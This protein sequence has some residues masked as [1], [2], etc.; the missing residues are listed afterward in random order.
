MS[1]ATMAERAAHASERAREMMDDNPNS[2]VSKARSLVSGDA[3][4]FTNT[5]K[6]DQIRKQLDSDSVSDKKD[7]MK[8]VIAQICKGANMAMLF[9]D[10]VKNIHVSSIELRKLVYYFIV[11]YAEERPNESLLS[12]SAFQKDLLDHS[13]HVRSLALRILSS[14][15]IP[16]IN[17]VVM[18]AIKKA[19][20]DMSSVVRK[21]AAISL[22]QAHSISGTDNDMELITGLLHQF[23]GDRS[24]EVVGA[25]ALSFMEICPSR[26]DLVHKHFRK[27]CRSLVDSDEWGQVVLLHMLLRYARTQFKNPDAAKPT[28]EEKDKAKDEKKAKKAAAKDSDDSDDSSSSDSDDEIANLGDSI[29]MDSDHRLLLNSVRPLFMSLN[30]AVIIGAASLYF[31]CAPKEELDVCVRPLLRLLAWSDDGTDVI[32]SAIH[33]FIMTRPTP[34]IPYVKEFYILAEDPPHI[35]ELKI[36][37]IS[38]LTTS[39]NYVS[40]IHEFRSYLRSFD[41]RKV[42]IA[43]HGLGL[44]SSSVADCNTQIMRLISP[45]LSHRHPDVVTECVVVL[46][47]L[48]VQGTDKNQT[49]KLVHKLLLSVINGEI[50]APAARASILWLV[51]ENISTHLSIAK[52]APDCFRIFAKSFTTEEPVVKKQVLTLGAKLWLHLD[53]E[54]E[55]ADRF[56]K[57]FFYVLELVKYDTDYEVRDRG[58]LI[59]CS[60]DR[61]SETFNSFKTAT[62]APKPQPEQNDPFSEKAKYQLGSL[63]HLFGNALLGYQELPAWPETQPDPTVRNPPQQ[64]AS[65]DDD[66]DASSSY[67]SSGYGYGSS[68]R[69]SSRS[70][71]TSGGSSS[72]SSSSGSSRSGS[73]DGRRGGKRGAAAAASSDD[74]SESSDGGAAA[75][76]AKK[77]Q[78]KVV[79][80]RIVTRVVTKPGEKPKDKMID[81]LFKNSL[82]AKAAS[83]AA[84]TAGHHVDPVAEHAASTEDRGEV[85]EGEAASDDEVGAPE[86]DGDAVIEELDAAKK[87]D[88]EQEAEE[89]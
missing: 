81:E 61:T 49:C 62:L 41:V 24:P 71:S 44:I 35:R 25:A 39:G 51:G 13:M 55:L 38:K 31:H 3:Q 67:S 78:P 27:I 21:T 88:E 46:R 36:R 72:R 10:V 23:L 56:R 43:V 47:Q 19:S 84:A 33:T 7:G 17:P 42:I 63:S 1:R 66:E 26:V 73:E 12:I 15:R 40:V 57:I 8:R 14:I 75:A 68:S 65:S 79:A 6:I 70:S 80:T 64:V 76:A 77:P 22:S 74:E 16:A 52:A 60:L 28:A 83:G 82:E 85:V 9:P 58:R 59:E 50:K 4:F 32:L 86:A 37:I 53:G 48:V 89:Q 20:T 34:F 45:L 29:S 54:G 69:S 18:V 5:A 2:V 30:R 11:H 87:S